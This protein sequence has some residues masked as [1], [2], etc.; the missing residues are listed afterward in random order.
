M[1]STL[2]ELSLRILKNFKRIRSPLFFCSKML[3]IFLVLLFAV[4]QLKRALK[5]IFRNFYN[6]SVIMVTPI[7]ARCT[8][9]PL[10]NMAN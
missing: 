4:I 8:K 10:T 3:V 6:I 7:C 5:G 9:S 2:M 1:P